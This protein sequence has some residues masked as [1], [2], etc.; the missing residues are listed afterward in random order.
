LLRG[1]HSQPHYFGWSY[2]VFKMKDVQV[3]KGLKT[4]IRDIPIPEPGPDQV[5]IKVIVSGSNPKDW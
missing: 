3:S 5:V 2:I 1:K 4:V